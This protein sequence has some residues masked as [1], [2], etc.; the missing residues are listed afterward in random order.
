MAETLLALMSSVGTSVSTAAASITPMEAIGAG[1]STIG[2]LYSGAQQA[3]AN[4]FE[5]KQLKQEGDAKF[6]ASQAE[7]TKRRRE[8]KLAQSR[9]RAIAAASGAG[10]ATPTID[11][12]MAGIQT[13][14]DYNS[15]VE[16]YQ[17][18]SQRNKNYASAASLKAENPMGAAIFK[19]IGN[20]Y[21][22]TG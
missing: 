19:P 18:T 2:T 21:S 14:S 15:L 9:V 13:Q 5:A 22:R 12:I 1:V 4:K 10:V 7:A 8:G 6:A 3:A 16:M 20:L 17:G 11:T